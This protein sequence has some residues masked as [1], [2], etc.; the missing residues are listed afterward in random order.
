MCPVC[1]ALERHRL[2][3]HF[4]HNHLNIADTTPRTLLQFAPVPVMRVK[5][6][7]MPHLRYIT[8]DLIDP[9]V[10]F[11]VDITQLSLASEAVDVILCSHVL[12][13]IPDDNKAMGEMFR[14]LKPGGQLIVMVPFYRT[15]T[16]EA[17]D[18]DD[19]ERQRLFDNPYHVRDYGWDIVTR[20]ADCGYDVRAYH[21]YEIFS[22]LQ[23]ALSHP[24]KTDFIF[25]AQKL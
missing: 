1:G 3:W 14:V 22:P 9:D 2:L 24:V 7:Q 19:A 16:L 12:E 21:P 18:A 23:V 13:H 5:F 11:H 8:T 25:L 10:D 17:L 20:L 4:L 15:H 6:Q